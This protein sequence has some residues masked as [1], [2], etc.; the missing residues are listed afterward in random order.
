MRNGRKKIQNNKLVKVEITI[1]AYPP[2]E[3]R[4]LERILLDSGNN[5][6]D[7]SA[8]SLLRRRIC[9]D[10]DEGI[11]PIHSDA[12]KYEFYKAVLYS[13]VVIFD[14]TLEENGLVLGDNYAFIPY[15]NIRNT[16]I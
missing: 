10:V 13:D 9:K 3:G 7:S 16:Y 4:T 2:S 5:A 14:G 6:S 8:I 15:V 11:T 12:P 1:F